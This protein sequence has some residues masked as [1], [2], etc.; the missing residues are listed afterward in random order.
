MQKPRDSSEPQAGPIVVKLGKTSRKR[1]KKLKEGDGPL[2]TEVLEAVEQ[3][4]AGVGA[5]GAG[6]LLLPIVL[7]YAEKKKKGGR[8]GL[9]LAR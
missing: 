4:R 2:M 3:V 6:K 9:P 7:I 5:K 1:L 8:L